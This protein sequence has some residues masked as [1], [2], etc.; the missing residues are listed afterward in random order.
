MTSHTIA[1][2]EEWEAAR[3]E[4]LR[5]EK[6]H[7]RVGD[8]LARRRRELPWVAVENQYVLDRTTGSAPWPSSST[9]APNSSSTTSCSGRVTRQGAP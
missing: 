6:E 1:G 9:A 2:R 3:E 8:E 7:T 5:L 4:L